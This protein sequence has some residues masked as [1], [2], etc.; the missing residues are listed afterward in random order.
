MLNQRRI[1][2]CYLA[3]EDVPEFVSQDVIR[4]LRELAVLPYRD[5]NPCA[6]LREDDVR[7]SEICREIRTLLECDVDEQFQV[8]HREEFDPIYFG[9]VSNGPWLTTQ[10]SLCPVPYQFWYQ[11]KSR[12]QPEAAQWFMERAKLGAIGQKTL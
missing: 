12:L 4:V 5:F 9:V 2:T 8:V 3:Y 11:I 1:G 6:C 10:G 7:A